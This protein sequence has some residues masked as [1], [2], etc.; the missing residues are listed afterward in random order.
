LDLQEPETCHIL[1]T[2]NEVSG[3]ADELFPLLT[4]E[5]LG[6][7]VDKFGPSKICGFVRLNPDGVNSL[8]EMSKVK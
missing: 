6:Y 5:K 3:V 2:I 1:Q 7:Q 4:E 8:T